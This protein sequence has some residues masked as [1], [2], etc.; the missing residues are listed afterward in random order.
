[1]ANTSLN[2]KNTFL[3]VEGGNSFINIII[4]DHEHLIEQLNQFWITFLCPL[5][6]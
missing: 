3:M 2:L 6:T 4:T 5:I 1:M